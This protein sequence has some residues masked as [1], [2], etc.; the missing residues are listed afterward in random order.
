MNLVCFSSGFA[1]RGGGRGGG[2]IGRDDRGGIKRE[3]NRL[4]I[5]QMS[6]RIKVL[7]CI[8]DTAMREKSD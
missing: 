2:T 6:I 4:F 8:L 7:F 1:R 5:T 3:D